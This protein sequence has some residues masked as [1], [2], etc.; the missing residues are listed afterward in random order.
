MAL[1]DFLQPALWFQLVHGVPVDDPQGYL[2]RAAAAWLSFL[3]VQVVAHRRFRQEPVWLAVVA[4]LRLSDMLA[5]CTHL[6]FAADFS[7]L[8]YACLLP[9]WPVTA[10]AT[11]FLIRAY[12]RA[13]KA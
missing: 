7:P 12:H 8:G 10:L 6:M 4:G 5:D 3:L 11:L 9:A 1:V 2:P 13:D